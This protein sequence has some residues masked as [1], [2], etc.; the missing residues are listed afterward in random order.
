MVRLRG[1]I[2]FQEDYTTRIN[3][4]LAGGLLNNA[5]VDAF[6]DD[7]FGLGGFEMVDEFGDC[8]RRVG[9]SE[10][11]ATSD[12]AE[13]ENGIHDV[14]EHMQT[15][16]ISNIQSMFGQATDKLSDMVAS[17]GQ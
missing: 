14:I 10:T 1:F 9:S 5:K 12:N 16:G 3:T 4:T 6:G 17:G 8:I 13:K 15:D 7:K 2:L 11:T